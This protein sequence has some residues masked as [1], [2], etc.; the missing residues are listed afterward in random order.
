MNDEA[1]SQKNKVMG[2]GASKK[3]PSFFRSLVIF[4]CAS[5]CFLFSSNIIHFFKRPFTIDPFFNIIQ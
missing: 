5:C 3:S 1:I 4:A 2:L